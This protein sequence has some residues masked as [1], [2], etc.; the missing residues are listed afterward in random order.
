MEKQTR[1]Q[2]L[3]L[4]ILL[5]QREN[6]E[7]K[8]KGNVKISGYYVDRND[9]SF[10]IDPIQNRQISTNSDIYDSRPITLWAN[11][12]KGA[13]IRKLKPNKSGWSTIKIL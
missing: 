5:C 3:E 13:L 2:K 1:G 10:V 6:I 9:Y 11:E 7:I 12:L 4:K 8:L